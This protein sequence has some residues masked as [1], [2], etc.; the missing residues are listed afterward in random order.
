MESVYDLRDRILKYHQEKDF[1]V[2]GISD[3][4]LKTF[5]NLIAKVQ[6]I[7]GDKNADKEVIVFGYAEGSTLINENNIDRY[8]RGPFTV[9]YYKNDKFEFDRKPETRKVDFDYNYLG[10]IKRIE[11]RTKNVKLLLEC[12][13]DLSRKANIFMVIPKEKTGTDEYAIYLY[14]K[15]LKEI[16]KSELE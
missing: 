1:K 9:I 16:A 10:G 5:Y 8:Y 6:K 11:L 14:N 4:D 2:G 13:S 15:D 7:I 3:N 12:I